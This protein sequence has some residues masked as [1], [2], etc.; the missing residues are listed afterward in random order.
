MSDGGKAKRKVELL[1]LYEK[2]AVMK[3]RKL[4]VSAEDK[5]KHLEEKLQTSGG[6]LP[7]P[8]TLKGWTN[9]FSNIYL[10]GK[11]DYPP[12][13]FVRSKVCSVSGC[14]VMVMLWTLSIDPWKEAV[15]V[16]FSLKFNPRKGQKMKTVIPH[17]M[18]L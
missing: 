8:K 18:D 10:V 11:E 13:I 4:D 9:N 15:F 14:F 5:N 3:Q 17:T 6:K 7:D 16:S 2:A 1:D 12:R